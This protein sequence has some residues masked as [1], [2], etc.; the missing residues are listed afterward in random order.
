TFIDDYLTPANFPERPLMI[1]AGAYLGILVLNAVFG[2]VQL[3]KFQE[4]ALRIVRQVRIDAFTKVHRLG[5]RYFDQTPAGG[6]V[7]RVT[8]DTEA[9]LEMFVDVLVVFLQSS[10]LIIGVYIAMFVLDVRL[11]ILSLLLLPL[12]FLIMWIYR[13]YSSEFYQDLRERLSQL[14]GKIAESLNG[15][16]MVQVFRQEKRFREEFGEI[17]DKHYEAGMR[18][19]K[20]DGLLL[21]P[22]VD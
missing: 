2:Y 11:A 1:L 17:N 6:T 21:R 19:I 8:N 15:M 22:A 3:L 20:L 12:I 16:G 13:K 10:L 18:N 7:S 14:N 4:I 5:M 9:I